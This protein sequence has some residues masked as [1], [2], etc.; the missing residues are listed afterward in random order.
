VF[1]GKCFA[2]G[3]NLR[4]QVETNEKAGE[5]IAGPFIGE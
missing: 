4:L 1:Y 2:S 3:I 5:V